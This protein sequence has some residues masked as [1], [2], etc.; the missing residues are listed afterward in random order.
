MRKARIVKD[1]NKD[2]ALK[3]HIGEIV[4]VLGSGGLYNDGMWA[5][6]FNR[7]LPGTWKLND[8]PMYNLSQ[9]FGRYVWREEF[10][11]IDEEE[12]DKEYLDLFV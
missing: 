4:H 1:V 2:G 8:N 12:Q 9:P 3:S 6:L 11:Y 10:K 7:E 5:V